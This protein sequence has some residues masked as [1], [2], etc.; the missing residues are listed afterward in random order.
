[1]EQSGREYVP[2]QVGLP[3]PLSADMRAA[4]EVLK[5][6]LDTLYKSADN[7]NR[8]IYFQVTPTT[9]PDLPPEANVMNPT[10]YT[11]PEYSG[12]PIVITYKA[13]KGFIGGLLSS[14]MGTDDNSKPTA[15]AGTSSSSGSS[16]TSGGDVGIQNPQYIE[17]ASAPPAPLSGGASP[18]TQQQADEAYARYL[19]QQYDNQA[20]QQAPLP[21]VAHNGVSYP[22][23]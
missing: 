5:Y 10:P 21:P 23:L 19:Q 6:R 13:P 1:M 17:S 2:M 22:K 16:S 12:P 8:F 11:E 3:K 15:A 14:L 20:R 18:T 4:V 9:L 7:D